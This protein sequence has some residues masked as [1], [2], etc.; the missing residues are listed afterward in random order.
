MSAAIH[1]TII[2]QG[3][4]WKIN[5]I[6]KDSAGTVIPLTDYSAA[7]QIRTNYD[8]ASA[9][10]SLSTGYLS[11]DDVI[12]KSNTSDEIGKTSVTFLVTKTSAFTVGQRVRAASIN[13]PSNFQE[14]LVTAIS[15]DV[16]VTINVDLVGGSG[17]YSS[18]IFSSAAPGI[19]IK[20]TLGEI[21][22]HATAAQTGALAAGD[23][24]YDLEVTV[25]GEVTRL[26]QGRATLRPQV[27]R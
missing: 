22:I 8:A 27:T 20:P 14:G 4:D 18:W 23:Y 13:S 26:I 21:N 11:V 19:T 2:D 7:L 24:V 16:S 1:N 3:S 25:S 6:Y 5:L 17:T 12:I 9:S 15:T 10:L